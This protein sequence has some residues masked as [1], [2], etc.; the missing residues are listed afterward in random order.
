[1]AD[2]YTDQTRQQL[3][4]SHAAIAAEVQKVMDNFAAADA[5]LGGIL[6]ALGLSEDNL[7]TAAHGVPALFGPYLNA[8]WPLAPDGDHATYTRRMEHVRRTLPGAVLPL[9]ELPGALQKGVRV[10]LADRQT[11]AD[12]TKVR[13]AEA[14]KAELHQ[15]RLLSEEV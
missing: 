4:L 8:L 5:A 11:D 15:V 12:P 13:R 9:Y 7:P 10:R 3:I 14:Y 6:T 2:V 1:M